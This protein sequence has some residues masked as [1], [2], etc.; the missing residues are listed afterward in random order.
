MVL[1]APRSGRLRR[2]VRPVRPPPPPRIGA[3]VWRMQKVESRTGRPS[4]AAARRPNPLIRRNLPMPNRV[5]TR[6]QP[7]KLPTKSA[8]KLKQRIRWKLLLVQ[9]PSR[10]R[11]TSARNLQ[12]I[13]QYPQKIET[14][15][16]VAGKRSGRKFRIPKTSARNR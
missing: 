8:Q 5:E 10:W 3:T 16:P 12:R 11:N 14:M 15:M 1:P 7:R 6:G 4:V 13:H 9:L 2:K